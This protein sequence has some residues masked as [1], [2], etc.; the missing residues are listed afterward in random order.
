M[1]AVTAIGVHDDLATRE[2]RISHGSADDESASRIDMVFRV[3]VHHGLGED[4]LDDFVQ[5]G[6]VQI[7][8]RNFLA[9][10]GGN[11][12]AINAGRAAVNVFDCDLGFSVGAEEV[13]D[14]GLA[15]FSE[16]ARELVRDLDGHGHQLGSLIAGK[17]E[18]QSLI[19]GAAGVHA[20]GD[21]V[22]LLLDGADDTTGFSVEAVLGAG[23]A[24]VTDHFAGDIGEIDVGFRG[25]FTG[26]DN[27]TGGDQRLTGH[28]A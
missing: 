21:V 9:V 13:N 4:G 6:F 22:R 15:D 26:N 8:L 2:A 24:D 10:L 5:D 19:A 11:Y 18:H 12:R 25:D 14:P 1:A 3:L 16:T 17:A 28:A 23:V 7:A 27:E 20:H